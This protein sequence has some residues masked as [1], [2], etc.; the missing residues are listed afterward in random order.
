MVRWPWR[1]DGLGTGTAPA[2]PAGAGGV[3]QAP[4]AVGD[5]RPPTA[6]G[7]GGMW[8]EVFGSGNATGSDGAFVNTG[9]Y[10]STVQ[11]PPEALVPPAEVQAPPGLDNLPVRLDTFVGRARELERLDAALSSGGKRSSRRSTGWAGSARAPWPRTGPPPV[12]MAMPPSGGSPPT[13]P[14]PSSRV[15]PTSPPPCNPPWPGH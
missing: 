6:P 10:N 3:G 4:L 12:P 5:A 8:Q 14:P 11:L 13:A 1:K 9:I 2:V 15:W 7:P